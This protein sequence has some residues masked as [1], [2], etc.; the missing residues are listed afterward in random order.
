[1]SGINPPFDTH[2][3]PVVSITKL[4]SVSRVSPVSCCS[5]APFLTP[6]QNLFCTTF[7]SE[8]SPKDTVPRSVEPRPQLSYP[9]LCDAARSRARIRHMNPRSHKRSGDLEKQMY[10]P[11]TFPAT[12]RRPLVLLPAIEWTTNRR[13]P[14]AIVYQKQSEWCT[15]LLYACQTRH[16]LVPLLAACSYVI[17]PRCILF[18]V[19]CGRFAYRAR[20][21]GPVW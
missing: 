19:G 20:A 13:R 4:S 18:P 9:R 6:P 8:F 17:A 12:S 11:C 1:V 5:N 3:D 2:Y 15:P 21:P 7:L 10:W 16:A 14:C